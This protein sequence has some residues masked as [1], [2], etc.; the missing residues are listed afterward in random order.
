MKEKIG[1]QKLP[2]FNGIATAEHLDT[3]LKI[4]TYI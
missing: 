4:F 2:S 1:G 3:K